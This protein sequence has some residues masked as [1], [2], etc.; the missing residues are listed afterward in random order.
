LC[1]GDEVRITLWGDVAESFDD[2]V[3]HEHTNPIIVVFA[4]FQVTEFKGLYENIA[5]QIFT[6]LICTF[7][8]FAPCII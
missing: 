5:L 1:R 6:I 2:S 7:H 3:L 4:G 8:L